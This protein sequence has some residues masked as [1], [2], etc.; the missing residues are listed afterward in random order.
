MGIEI[1]TP[2]R[3]IDASDPI[4]FIVRQEG[5]FTLEAVNEFG[6]VLRSH[7]FKENIIGPFKNLILNQGLDRIATTGANSLYGSFHV[8][9]GTAVPTAADTQL[10]QA[11]GPSVTFN[12]TPSAGAPPDYVSSQLMTGTSAI[13]AYGTVNLTEIGVG[14]NNR[15]QLFSRALIVDAA[16]N[17]T[18]FPISSDEQLRVTY[19]LKQYP[20]LGDAEFQVNVSG[21]R[22]VI[23]RS[24]NVNNINGWSPRSPQTVDAN[25]DIYVV[26]SSRAFYTGGLND[27]TAT[28][29][30]GT[31]V[32]NTSNNSASLSPYE[33]GSH[34]RQFRINWAS[35]QGNSDQLRTSRVQLNCCTFQV[36]YEP[37]LSKNAEQTLF[38]EYEIA[39]GRR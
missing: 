25:F 38:L 34:K 39:W 37:P 33:A 6:R 18:A 10:A 35:N 30:L 5:W 1:I 17:P 21:T 14:S 13:G 12:G 23:V 7:E 19:E 31:M 4:P 36:Q 24:L 32:S 15:N 29:P 3:F 8:G 26:Q 22:D 2:G 11:V 20:P 28:Q 9:T 16:G 27:I